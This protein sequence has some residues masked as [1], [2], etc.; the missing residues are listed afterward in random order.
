MCVDFQICRIEGQKVPLF[1]LKS[2]GGIGYDTTD[3]TAIRYRF[4]EL[5]VDRIVYVVD[6]GQQLHFDLVFAGAKRMGW[7]KV[8]TVL[9]RGTYVG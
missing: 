6:A 2:N 7:L 1:V 9:V 5:G 8:R 3:L 4:E